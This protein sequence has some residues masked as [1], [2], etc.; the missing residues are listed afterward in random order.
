MCR[1]SPGVHAPCVHKSETTSLCLVCEGWGC[2]SGCHP[3]AESFL[4][5]PFPARCSPFSPSPVKSWYHFQAAGEPFFRSASRHAH[6]WVSRAQP[7]PPYHSPSWV[8]LVPVSTRWSTLLLFHS[9]WGS[10]P[11]PCRAAMAKTV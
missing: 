2:H 5:S 3:G 10:L 1:S 11:V 8:S 6:P 7:V 4:R 9:H